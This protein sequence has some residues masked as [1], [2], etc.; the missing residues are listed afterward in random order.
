MSQRDYLHVLFFCL[1]SLT[2]NS[3]CQQ[4]L[5]KTASQ[6]RKKSSVYSSI[7]KVH[8]EDEQD[9]SDDES[10]QNRQDS[11][12]DENDEDGQ[13]SSDDKSDQDGQDSSYREGK[14]GRKASDSIGKEKPDVFSCDSK[15]A[16]DAEC[17]DLTPSGGEV[18]CKCKN[19][20]KGDGLSKSL[21][22]ETT[23]GGPDLKMP[24]SQCSSYAADKGYDFL[25]FSYGRGNEPSGCFLLGGKNVF[26]NSDKGQ[27]G[28]CNFKKDAKCIKALDV[29]PNWADKNTGCV[30]CE[31]G[32]FGENCSE[33]YTAKT[34]VILMHTVRIRLPKVEK[35]T[36]LVKTDLR[37]MVFQKLQ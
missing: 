35:L 7:S 33:K 22:Y 28:R 3:S 37:V 29:R 34:A 27:G 4:E 6:K 5:D 14:G 36:V 10:D 25:D 26:Y 17:K 15:C 32:F 11:S 31:A 16:P 18:E 2:V 13:D 9:S 1:A 21:L 19:G 12:D 30:P 20:F 23:E 24:E 8:L